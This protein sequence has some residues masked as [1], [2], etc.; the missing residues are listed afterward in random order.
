MSDDLG[1]VLESFGGKPLGM[2]LAIAGGIAALAIVAVVVGM[3]M[4]DYLG[5]AIAAAVVILLIAIMYI[6]TNLVGVFTK[7][8]ICQSGLRIKTWSGVQE[9][10]WNDIDRIEVGKHLLNGKLRWGVTIY[11]V[12]GNQHDLS[13]EF[14]DSAGGPSKFIATA[15]QFATVNMV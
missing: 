10:P 4:P 12:A 14:W 8:E 11:D 5:G 3:V 13:P 6:A 9:L 7:A 2:V 1:K 15:R